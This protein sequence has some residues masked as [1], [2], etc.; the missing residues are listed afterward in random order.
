MHAPIYLCSAFAF[1]VAAV[2]YSYQPGKSELLLARAT[3]WPNQTFRTTNFQPPV[4]NITKSGKKLA[5]GL[6]LFTPAPVDGSGEVAALIT[7]DTGDLVWNSV[8]GLSYNNLFVQSLNSKPIL[9]MW[10]GDGSPNVQVIGHGYG[11]VSILDTTYTEIYSI[12][13]HFDLVTPNNYNFTCNA[14]L[15]E[16]YVTERGSILV[17]AYNIT[18]AD[19]T[20]VNGTSKGYIYDSLF[21]EIDIKTQKIL[22]RWSSLE[23]GIPLS[24]SKV[25]ITGSGTLASPWDWFHINSIQ[26]VGRGYLINSRH[27]W[28]SY[29][30][31]SAGNIQWNITVSSSS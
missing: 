11:R 29:L 7:T 19:L 5:P 22:F 23:A 16:S 2:P 28:T 8:P 30:L 9:T 1:G 18:T 26:S 13:P 25:P 21:Y 3:T 14:D 4:L 12:C 10:I 24:K 15:H 6:L 17:T 27:L 20:S 31:D